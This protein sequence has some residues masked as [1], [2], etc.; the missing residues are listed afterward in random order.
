MK[1]IP[2][3]ALISFLLVGAVACKKEENQGN[4]Q[5]TGNTRYNSEVFT[6]VDVAS[7][8]VYGS[9]TTQGGVTENLVMDIYTPSGDVEANRPLI[10]LAHGG[11]FQGGDKSSMADL[12]TFFAKSGYVAVSLKYRIVDIQP[13]PDVMKRAVIDA[14]QDMRAAV[15]FF[16]KDLATTNTYRINPNNIFVGGY[17]AG[18]FMGLHTAYLNSDAELV[19]MG[20][21][22]LLD[23]TNAS[24]G[25]EGNSGNPGH[26]SAV[27]GAISIA[28][29]LGKASFINAGEPILY[30]IHG[31]AD[32]VV[33]Y[34]SGD[35]D[36]SG[37]ITE[38][39]GI[40]H[41]VADAAGITN[42][43][44]THQNGTHD[45]LWQVSNS[46]QDIRGFV[47]TN[48]AP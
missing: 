7:D 6:N 4:N 5:Q 1:T 48:L 29:A 15:R 25:H 23:Y 18:A 37:V 11:G 14:V 30:S 16:R 9:S 38:G 31:T 21:Q 12:A 43:L 26:S 28:G 22:A 42:K 20:G 3:L 40:Y 46:Y 24:G 33:P 36:G 8:V 45:V 32:Q 2:K 41:P 17:S 35:S 44:Y 47:F 13:T 34:Y 10:I 39:P 27:R 19:E